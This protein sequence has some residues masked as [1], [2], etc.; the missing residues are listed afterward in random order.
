MAANITAVLDVVN[1][2]ID[3]NWTTISAFSQEGSTY[4]TLAEDGSAVTSSSIVTSSFNDGVSMLPVGGE[5]SGEK[6]DDAVWILTSTF[7][8]FTMQS[9]ECVL[10]CSLAPS[11]SC[12]LLTC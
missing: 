1:L 10:A 5:N 3:V 7:I 2:A 4:S 6:A 12:F 11:L 9:G 8:I